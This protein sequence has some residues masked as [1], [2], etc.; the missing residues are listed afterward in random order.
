MHIKTLIYVGLFL[1][2]SV[3]GFSQDSLNYADTIRLEDVVVVGQREESSLFDR[4]EA[5]SVLNS[6]QLE[7]TSPMN[8]PD[9]MRAMPGVFMQ[10]TNHGGGSP[11]VRGLTG[12]HTLILVDGIRLNNAIFR[13]GPNQYLNTVDPLMI[14]QIEVLRGPGSVQYGT[15]A[16]GGTI[17]LRSRTPEFSE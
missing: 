2:A 8:M 9:A 4:P 6:R 17:Y 14:H 13:S 12:Y 11:F 5:I 15:D 7:S 1:S 10:E 16:I 3:H